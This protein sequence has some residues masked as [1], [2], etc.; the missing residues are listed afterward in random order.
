MYAYV[1]V[2]IHT[3][4]HICAMHAYVYVSEMNDSNDTRDWK[5]EL[6]VFCY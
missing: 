3:C 4:I 6:G 2:Y 1:Y 5:K